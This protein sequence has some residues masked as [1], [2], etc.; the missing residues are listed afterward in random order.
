M[1]KYVVV[2]GSL[3]LCRQELNRVR[4]VAISLGFSELVACVGA[5]LERERAALPAGAPP[6]CALQL[7]H[8]AA[9]LR[10]PRTALDV[11]HTLQP[12]AP[13]FAVASM[14]H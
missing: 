1:M 10:D 8:A 14:P 6:E 4:R 7:A 13:N 9:A 5:A 12:L 3:A 11:K 2:S